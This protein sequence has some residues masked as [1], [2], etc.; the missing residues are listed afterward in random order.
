MKKLFALL[1]AL[2]MVLSLAACGGSQDETENTQSGGETGEKITLAVFDAH[3]YG[4]EEYAEMEAQFEADHA[5][6]TVEVQH[7][8]NDPTTILQSRVNSGEIP[9]VF[10]IESGT[11]A[12]MYYEYAYDWSNDTEALALFNEDSL[13]TGAD[14]NGNIKGLPFTYETMGLLYN[15]DCFETAGITELPTTIAELEEACQK[16]E[17]AGITPF[18]IPAKETWVLGQLATNFMLDKELGAVGTVEAINN[19]ELKFADMPH[20]NNLFAFLDLAVKYGPDKPLELDWETAEN[21][22][23]NGEAAMIQMG[24]WCQATLDGF[25]PD[26]NLGMMPCPV[27]DGVEDS[28]LMSK[29]NWVYI[30]NKDSENLELAKEYALHILASQMGQEWMTQTIG[31]VPGAKTELEV[32]GDLANDAK[33]YIAEGRTDSWIHTIAPAAYGET[34]GP[35]MQAYMLG[36]MTA[37]EVTQGFQEFWDAAQ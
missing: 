31:A 2:T 6:V 22:L 11:N 25:N 33:A 12:A 4:L 28:T 34:C 32:N 24:D 27:G 8:A 36:E 7:V 30:V 1:L 37:E 29:C 23:A 19:G 13:T 3:A 9:D 15:K 20:W 35:L 18:A 17:A 14:E 26:A 10:A 16:L 5:G 21:M